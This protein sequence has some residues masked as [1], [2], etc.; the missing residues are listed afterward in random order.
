MPKSRVSAVQSSNL[1]GSE[2]HINVY[3]LWENNNYVVSSLLHTKFTRKD[4]HTEA[5]I[6]SPSSH[7]CLA[8][9]PYML[10]LPSDA[11]QYFCGLG[12]YHSG[13]EVY[14]SEYAYG[15]HDNR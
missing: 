15:A 7:N 11:V 14:D 9:E 8:V 1:E 12:I 10:T 2:V 4:T 6:L 5:R 3:D 13:V